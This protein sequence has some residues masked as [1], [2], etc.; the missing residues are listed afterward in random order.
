MPPTKADAVLLLEKIA[1]L[2][3]YHGENPFKVRAYDNAAAALGGNGASLTELTSEPE[4]LTSI[5]GIGKALAD[6]ICEFTARGYSSYYEELQQGVPSDL[7][8]LIQIPGLGAKKIRALHDKLGIQTLADLERVAQSGDLA[9]VPGFSKAAGEKVLKALAQMKQ[10]SGRILVSRAMA[11]A[12]PLLEALRKCPDVQ[13]AELA[14]SLRR[15]KETVGDLDLVASSDN[16]E[17]VMNWFR[18]LPM[19]HTVIGSGPTKTSVLL[20]S[21]V[22]ADL[23]VVRDD[24]YAAALHHFTGS[25]EHNTSLRS[26]A[27]KQGYLVNEY[28]VFHRKNESGDE[29]NPGEQIAVKTETELFAILGLDFIEPELREG[30]EEIEA[31][32]THSLPT[33]ILPSDYLGVLHCHT[34]WSDGKNSIREMALEAR[35][36]LGLQY[37]GLGD[38]SEA[39]AYAGGIRK[40]DIE[41]QHEEIDS[42]NEELG[43]ADFRVLKGTECDILGDGALDYPDDILAR[44][45]YVVASVHSRFQMS[46]EEMTLRLVR[47]VQNPY[48]TILG[49]P[50]GRLLLSREGYEFDVD[51]VLR[52]CAASGTYIEINA[53]PHRLDLDWRFCRRAK[54]MGIKF[55][56]NPDAHSLQ[57]LHNIVYGIWSARKG[58]L[59]RHDVVNC[60]P[61]DEFLNAVQEL[62]AHKLAISP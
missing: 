29:G 11:I 49:H 19:A 56:I 5:K 23:R 14:G 44:M 18:T 35:D 7:H 34:T 53:D 16:A 48:T 58:W 62:R 54:E 57:A 6:V 25:K 20:D 47:A 37:F 61:L 9:G 17:A 40:G 15:R 38:H 1:V 21:G 8:L 26:L 33:L 45:D 51:A 43:S 2:L 12:E 52:A 36:G 32:T 27:V 42:V 28:G 4:R 39:A 22:Q 50:S 31:A 59:S 13:R 55:A 46:A 3:S 24:Q 60:L 30:R 41:K 10:H